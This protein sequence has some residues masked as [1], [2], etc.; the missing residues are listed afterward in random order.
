MTSLLLVRHGST[1][2]TAERRLQGRTD[3]AL[4]ERGRAETVALRALVEPWAPTALLVSPAARA[5]E[6]AE[7]L[8]SG[9]L[10]TLVARPDERLLEAGLGE[11]EGRLPEELGPD[12]AAWRAGALVP[13]GGEPRELVAARI[14]AVLD[15]AAS[16]QGPVLV[17]THGGV[18]RAALD[19]LVGLRTAHLSPVAAASL[20][21]VEVDQQHGRLRHYNLSAASAA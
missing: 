9:P 10:G 1:P 13:P 19:R 17:V 4:D 6:T 11:W 2:W 15:D 5:M 12:Y 14:A 7:L 3:I 21:V 20:T 18:I 8:R 16:L